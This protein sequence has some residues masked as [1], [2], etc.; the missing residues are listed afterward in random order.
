[1]KSYTNTLVCVFQVCY[2]GQD[3]IFEALHEDLERD[4]VAVQLSIHC[5]T[6]TVW[7]DVNLSK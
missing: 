6:K 7:R 1:M 2:H 5:G 3:Y 4:L